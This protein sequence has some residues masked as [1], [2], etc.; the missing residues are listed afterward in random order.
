MKARTHRLSQIA[1]LVTAVL[2]L[3]G[4]A[5]LPVVKQVR[6]RDP[7]PGPEVRPNAPPEYDILVA[8]D[9]RARGDRDKVLAAF[10]RALE[11][12]PDSAYIHRELA[13][14][15]IRAGRP[16][17]S[18]EHAERALEL[19]PDHPRTRVFL[20]QLY[21]MQ[22]NVAAAELALLDESGE[23]IN[24][25]AGAL[26]FRVYM[27]SDRGE[28]AVDLAQW[29]IDVVDD[30]ITAYAALAK[31]YERTGQFEKAEGTLRQALEIEPGN[32][33]IYAQLVRSARKRGEAG[34]ERAIY[35]EILAEHPHHHATLMA[36]ADEQLGENDTDGALR[37]LSEI[38]AHYPNDTK[39]VV[40][41]GFLYYEAE[42]FP[43]SAKRFE[44]FLARKPGDHEVRFFLGIVRRRM[45]EDAA[46]IEV[47]SAI[48]EE[49]EHYAEAHT[50]LAVLFERKGE[51]ARAL[52]E[53]ELAVVATSTR[54]RELY[55]ATLRAKAGDFD[56]AV[57]YLE[58]LLL[59]DPD[60]DELLF[61]LGMVFGEA[62]RTQEA[63]E[64]M[65]RAIEENP[66]NASALNYVGYTWAERGDNLD[67]AE[68]Y[69]VRA[70]DL[71]PDDGFIIDSLGWVYYMRARPLFD[72]GRSEEAKQYIDR[73][74]KELLRA[75]ELTGG[76][77]VV[78]EHLGD[79]Y[80]LLDQK[81]R[82]LQRYQEAVDLT[83]R[84][85]EQPDLF[86]KLEALRR[87][88]E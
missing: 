30:S 5:L 45:G 41:L 20:G 28:Q 76:D 27:E 23:P 33:K 40:R 16:A 67:Q 22:H 13:V 42:N 77:P 52:E 54:P 29:L 9:H 26:L 47:F 2:L 11:K 3:S 37:T 78:S 10:E 12:D 7:G 14:V 46:A 60:D 38:E 71:R 15:L 63:I 81:H 86:E 6:V 55:A 34:S 83:P 74:L 75:Q 58:G 70:L 39:S 31:A 84:E 50:Q 43:E 87:E 49:S 65:E 51:F 18:L 19:D 36:L 24:E 56:G 59:E 80:L 88:I 72:T 21:R 69:I 82:A 57:A 4:C 61:N 1:L 64:Y 48:P 17:E 68:D 44:T 32:L 8:H 53:I 25:E 79:I 66:K 73:A 62:K 85:S 35:R